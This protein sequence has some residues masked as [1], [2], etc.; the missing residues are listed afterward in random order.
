M[1]KNRKSRFYLWTSIATEIYNTLP[2]V[3]ILACP[4]CHELGVDFQFAGDFQSKIGYM[5]IWC[6]CCLYGI[7]ISRVRIPEKIQALPFDASIEKIST[8]IPNFTHVKPY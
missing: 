8:R 2:N 6:P 3:P 7:H 1:N 4:S 5:A